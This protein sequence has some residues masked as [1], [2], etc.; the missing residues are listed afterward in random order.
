MSTQD[1]AKFI[2]LEIDQHSTGDNSAWGLENYF[3]HKPTKLLPLIEGY[4]VRDGNLVLQ[5]EEMS[6]ANKLDFLGENSSRNIVDS[7][8]DGIHNETI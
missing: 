7:L 6:G 2:T 8:G 5:N 1:K 4:E 3:T